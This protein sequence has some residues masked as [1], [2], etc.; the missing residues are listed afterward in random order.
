[1]RFPL[2]GEILAIIQN[3]RNVIINL[4]AV[5]NINNNAEFYVMRETVV[6][7]FKDRRIVGT[8]GV[9]EIQEARSKAEVKSGRGDI[10]KGDFVIVN[11]EEL[12]KKLEEE[13]LADEAALAELKQIEDRKRKEK[14]EARLI[15]E[16]ARSKESSFAG[17]ASFIRAGYSGFGLLRLGEASLNDYYSGGFGILADIFFYRIRTKRGG[18][19]FDFYSRYCYRQFEMTDR[20]Y[21]EFQ[22][23]YPALE[24]G[25]SG[26]KIHSLDLG[27][28]F[29]LGG[30]FLFSRIDFYLIGALRQAK[31]IE[32]ADN[33]IENTYLPMGITGG[34]GFEFS[35]YKRLA[36]FGEYN[37]GYTTVGKNRDNID[38]HQVFFGV[39]LRT[40]HI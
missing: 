2:E 39:S 32:S 5:N 27:G 23:N 33:H 24:Y 14:Q 1:M 12:I 37:Y 36:F 34:G 13:R 4:G 15:N 7:G 26:I 30:Y 9:I 16:E 40:D 35:F 11:Q 22:Y 28:R 8:V 6:E 10:L 29:V 18:N 19:G 38:G 3:G 21:R 17:S 31:V 20:T 25:K